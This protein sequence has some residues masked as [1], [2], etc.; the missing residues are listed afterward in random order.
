MKLS[1]ATRLF[2]FVLIAVLAIWFSFFATAQSSIFKFVIYLSYPSILAVF[3]VYCFSLFQLQRHEYRFRQLLP[4]SRGAWLT[5]V[6]IVL[7]L[8]LYEPFGFK[9]V[10]DEHILSGTAEMMHFQRL[11]SLPSGG[12]DTSGSYRLISSILDKRPVF[13]PFLLSLVHDLTGYRY[14]N[15]F[16]L[17][18][19]LSAL[20]VLLIYACGRLFSNNKGGIMAVLLAGT[21]PLLGSFAT[22]GHFEILN[23]VMIC[24]VLV[25]SY[26]Y[27][28]RPNE[29]TIV[30]LVF[31]LILLTQVRY[32]NT[33][34]LLPFGILILLGWK[35]NE[36]VILPWP[37]M[38]SPLFYI[39]F[40]MHY[41]VILS[42]VQ[43]VFQEGPNGRIHTFSLG[44]AVDNLTSAGEFLFSI[45]FANPNSYLLTILGFTA[46]LG[47]CAYGLLR[48][49]NLQ[50]KDPQGT[51]MFFFFMAISL[52]CLVII[53]FN[54][55]LFN[56]HITNRLSLPL[57]LL[58]I[59]II[60]F[61]LT[62]FRRTYV[63]GS[64]VFLLLSGVYHVY[65]TN[66][67]DIIHSGIQIGTAFVAGVGLLYW[68]YNHKRNT[69]RYFFL[70]PVSYILTIGMPVAHS[71]RY[72][73]EYNS[74][75]IVQL[76]FTFIEHRTDTESRIFWL[77]PTPYAGLMTRTNTGSL[78]KFKEAPS[79]LWNLVNEKYFS[80]V[81]IPRL[82][83]LQEDGTYKVK[84]DRDYLDPE[85]F[86]VE[87]V[88]ETSVGLGVIYRVDRLVDIKPQQSR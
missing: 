37:V 74:N 3:V 62:R 49:K 23:L 40:A 78:V 5:V 29:I 34:Y 53:F 58:F 16:I 15:V 13:F 69:I 72:E 9:I 79:Q 48:G 60:P 45:G 75:D 46:I 18:G 47:F 10:Y 22:S 55:G 39:V 31:G 56:R 41:R 85:R 64:L 17:N 44:Y 65:I 83:Y 28:R 80:D 6:T 70:V 51:V 54:Y 2:L 71:Q 50:G 63:L 7:L 88:F 86:E 82:F 81:Y 26:I 4:R 32:E 67:E 57:Q 19:L 30:P 52:N 38:I 66:T 77:T 61:I 12:N 36:T 35:K 68:I 20:L 43:T 84:Y 14:T 73:Q 11:S 76:D 21:L 42:G 25:L 24:S 59:L 33:L 8:F 87:T 27:I 1:T